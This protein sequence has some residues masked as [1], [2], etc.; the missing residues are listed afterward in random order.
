MKREGS[1]ERPFRFLAGSGGDA[2]PGF[3]GAASSGDKSKT[4]LTH[5]RGACV[6]KDPV[7]GSRCARRSTRA[8]FHACLANTPSARKNPT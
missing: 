2:R 3:R 1:G 8:R 4:M 6:A 5:P 7:S